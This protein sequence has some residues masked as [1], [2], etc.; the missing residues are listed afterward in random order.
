MFRFLG[1]LLI[2]TI[3]SIIAPNGLMGIVTGLIALLMSLAIIYYPK[4]S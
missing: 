3:A 2:V 4:R 1:V